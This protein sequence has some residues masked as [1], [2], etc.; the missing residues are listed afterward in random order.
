MA[1]GLL[2]SNK[3]ITNQKENILFIHISH[4]M[5]LLVMRQ[6]WVAQAIT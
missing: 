2:I 5:S 3:T 1:N 6:A 4:Q